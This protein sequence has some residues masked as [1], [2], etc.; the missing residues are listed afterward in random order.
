MERTPEALARYYVESFL[1][2][3][4]EICHPAAAP[5]ASAAA[6]EPSYFMDP[7]RPVADHGPVARG[8]AY[9]FLRRQQLLRC[10][11]FV[12]GRRVQALAAWTAGPT[13]GVRAQDRAL[14]AWWCPWVHD[15]ALMA[16]SVRH[17]LLTVNAMREDPV[18]PLGPAAVTEHV[19]KIF[20]RRP[21]SS[22]L[23]SSWAG[24]AAGT[25]HI[26]GQPKSFGNG[27]G[28]DGASDDDDERGGAGR[29]GGGGGG[30]GVT[31]KSEH[32]HSGGVG[33]VD[34]GLQPQPATVGLFAPDAPGVAAWVQDMGMQFP[35]RRAL[36]DRLYRV[37]EEINRGLP[38]AHPLRLRPPK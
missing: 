31:V 6:G 35:P 14:P 38:L 3:C 32:G 26:T 7:T 10:C 18:L 27:N 17:G 20:L 11:R 21:A 23:S 5:A 28:G 25:N 15:V 1:P 37:L 16:G 30:G 22:S 24:A 9:V 12:I 36:E 13:A 34:D 8:M 29:C 19:R 33:G 4:V 2:L